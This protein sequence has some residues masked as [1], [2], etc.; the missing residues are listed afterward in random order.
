MVAHSKHHLDILFAAKELLARRKEKKEIQKKSL[1]ASG[2][3]KEKAAQAGY[4]SGLADLALGLEVAEK[5]E[6][7]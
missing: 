5:G 3:T 4:I 7:E 2:T 6:E 1:G